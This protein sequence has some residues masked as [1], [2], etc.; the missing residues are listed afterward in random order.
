MSLLVS[1][2]GWQACSEVGKTKEVWVI[3]QLHALMC[4]LDIVVHPH[5]WDRYIYSFEFMHA[6]RS[7]I[8]YITLNVW[9]NW[10]CFIFYHLSDK[11]SRLCSY[12]HMHAA[13]F[14]KY[15]FCCTVLYNTFPFGLDLSQQTLSFPFSMDQCKDV[16]S[17]P[18]LAFDL[19][20]SKSK[21]QRSSLMQLCGSRDD[22][23]CSRAV[24]WEHYVFAWVL[25]AR[26]EVWPH[27]WMTLQYLKRHP[28]TVLICKRRV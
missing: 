2:A 3:R 8:I 13:Y 20:C 15:L 26:S 28:Q 4:C 6:C 25:M 10:A 11:H 18:W 17:R 24:K 23:R 19:C 22:I 21:N 9:S 16:T 14:H 1:D 12:R 5:E 27:I 7:T